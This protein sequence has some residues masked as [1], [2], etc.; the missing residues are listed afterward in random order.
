M[1]AQRVEVA[2]G[3]LEPSCLGGW[4]AAVVDVRVDWLED[5]RVCGHK[6]RGVDCCSHFLCATVR[7][8][9]GEVGTLLC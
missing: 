2:A 4:T 8:P 9:E 1:Q 3:P 5:Y 7:L 6:S